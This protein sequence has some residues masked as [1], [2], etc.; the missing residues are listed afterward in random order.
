M[1]VFLL[2]IKTGHLKHLSL[3]FRF[4]DIKSKVKSSKQKFKQM[5]QKLKKKHEKAQKSKQMN[6]LV[7]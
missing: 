6:A 3:S 7:H 5:R 2:I 1:L 4:Q